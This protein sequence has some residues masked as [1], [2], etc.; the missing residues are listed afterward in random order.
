MSSRPS[1]S[2][3]ACRSWSWC[4]WPWSGFARE[5][6]PA[7]EPADAALIIARTG[8]GLSPTVGTVIAAVCLF[9][10]AGIVLYGLYLLVF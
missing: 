6:E 10:A 1:R 9:G 7:G 4:R 5:P 8:S 2:S 3:S